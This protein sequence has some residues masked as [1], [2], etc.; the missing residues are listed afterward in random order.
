MRTDAEGRYLFTPSV[1]RPMQYR[2]VWP[3][4]KT[5]DVRTVRVY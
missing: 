1:W 2:V 3:E 4:I 5:S